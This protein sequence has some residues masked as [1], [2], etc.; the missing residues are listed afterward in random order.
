MVLTRFSRAVSIEYLPAG[1]RAPRRWD[2]APRFGDSDLSWVA[3]ASPR[4]LIAYDGRLPRRVAESILTPFRELLPDEN[5]I[6]IEHPKKSL[7]QARRLWS[8]MMGIKPECVVA[9]GGGTTTDLVSFAA[10]CFNRGTPTILIPTTLLAIVDASIGGKNGLDYQRCKNAIGTISHPMRV[11]SSMEALETLP[12]GEYRSGFGEIIKFAALFPGKLMDRLTSIALDISNPD[13]CQ[14][15]FE[16]VTECAAIKSELVEGTGLGRECMLYGHNIGHALEVIRKGSRHGECVAIGMAFEGALAVKAGVLSEQ[17][18][19]E[20]RHLLR[21]FG[22]PIDIPRG[23]R[24]TT[25]VH[26]MKRYRLFDGTEFTFIVP[27]DK[28]FTRVLVP[29]DQLP[30]L[31]TELDRWA[32]SRRG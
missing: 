14:D 8:I 26:A 20:Q 5:I 24:M 2:L 11:S 7:L 3:D 32:R 13:N 16:L 29:E 27:C 25:L 18:W 12:C 6:Q 15:A 10:S 19:V 21:S 4:T 22:L 28:G 9:I 17:R 1:E 23:V 31:L 30:G